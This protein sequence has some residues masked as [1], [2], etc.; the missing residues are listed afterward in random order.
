MA[1]PTRKTTS[2]SRRKIAGI[3][4]GVCLAMA[5][6]GT[7]VWQM[8][9]RYDSAATEALVEA[10]R[11]QDTTAI[12]EAIQAGADPNAR[13]P[14]R[15]TL[16]GMATLWLRSLS[17]LRPNDALFARRELTS[18]PHNALTKAIQ[19]G[20]PEAVSALLNAGANPN[21]PA[22]HGWTPL[23]YTA[24]VSAFM[25]ER[26]LAITRLLLAAGAD[27]NRRDAD[28]ATPLLVALYSHAPAPIVRLLLESGADTS[29][30]M[31]TGATVNHFL[32][33]GA[34]PEIVKL[35]REKEEHP[36]PV[37]SGG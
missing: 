32:A 14:E 11:S 34:K 24:N 13:F 35:F 29:V 37:R 15:R 17:P 26:C 1:T 21:L 36:R 9:P 33:S 23:A 2:L 7:V 25:P 20:D 5:M 31:S 8:Q 30:R 3:L 10:S 6:V 18:R 4:L 19:A 12:R 28:S 16:L 27:P 22:E